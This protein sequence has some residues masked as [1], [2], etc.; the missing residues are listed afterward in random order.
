[1]NRKFSATNPFHAL[2]TSP[3]IIY[4]YIKF[5]YSLHIDIKLFIVYDLFT[6]LN[7]IQIDHMYI[8]KAFA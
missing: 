5:D 3:A 6:Q 2:I 1:M 8:T 7:L 4:L